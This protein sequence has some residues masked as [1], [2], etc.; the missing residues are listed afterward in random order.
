MSEENWKKMEQLIE[1]KL[2]GVKNDFKVML[3]TLGKQPQPAGS[4]E[5]PKEKHK[6]I[7]EQIDCPECYSQIR[8]A[9]FKK[10][11]FKDKKLLCDDCGV[12]VD[13]GEEECPSCGGKNA[14][15]R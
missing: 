14:R 5:T 7:Q 2:Q 1:A 10:E 15:T 4:G 9:V 11:N 3:E 8:N 12:P 13:E 6:S